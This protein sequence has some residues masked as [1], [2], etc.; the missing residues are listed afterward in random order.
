M[1][2]QYMDNS[3]PFPEW[4]PMRVTYC[5]ELKMKEQLDKLNIENF[6]PMHYELVDTDNGRSLK[7]LPAIHN[8]IFV[9][10]TREDM[11]N[12]KMT[13]REL[14][15]LRY[16][17]R[18]VEGSKGEMEIIR[19][20]DK[21]M[22]DFMRVASVTDERVMFLKYS[23]YLEKVGQRVKVTNGFFAGVEGVIKRIRNNRR[24][25]VI[26]NGVAAVAIANVPVDYLMPIE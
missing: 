26:I 7:L 12:L 6:V 21:Q 17:M 16:M 25:V 15:P 19:V 3:I 13:R 1:S 9:R 5:R 20:P 22:E 8:L 2:N 11:T 4:F 10:A 23:N 18:P 14:E 24:V